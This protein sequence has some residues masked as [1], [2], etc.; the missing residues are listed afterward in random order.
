MKSIVALAVAGAFTFLAPAAVASQEC[1]A[2]PAG[3]EAHSHCGAA[4]DAQ[5]QGAVYKATGSVKDVNKA[6]GKVT[7]SH[8][9]VAELHWPAMTMRF[10]VSDRK[11][12]DELAAGKKVDFRFV[13]RGKEY[14]VTALY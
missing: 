11:L 7:I 2:A 12:L 6:A 10:G 8:D 1:K 4:A 13:Q 3:H 9:P 5:S 14:V